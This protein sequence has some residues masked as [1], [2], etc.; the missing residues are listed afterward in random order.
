MS[1][2]LFIYRADNVRFRFDKKLYLTLII[3]LII[4]YY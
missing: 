2:L 4:D 1:W 3:I